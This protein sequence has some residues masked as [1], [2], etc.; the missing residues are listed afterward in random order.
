MRV[1]LILIP[2]KQ[3]KKKQKK[4]FILDNSSFPR[5]STTLHREAMLQH[6]RAILISVFSARKFKI[7]YIQNFELHRKKIF[8]G[9]TKNS[10]KIFFWVLG[11]QIKSRK[12]F[13]NGYWGI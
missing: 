7:I 5:S 10:V 8:L 11:Y 3:S 4:S 1:V 12:M 9:G 6:G 2:K 13:L